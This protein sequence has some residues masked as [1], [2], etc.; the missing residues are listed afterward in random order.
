MHYCL[1]YY[2]ADVRKLSLQPD[3]SEHGKTTDTG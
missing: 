2:G 3:I 1:L